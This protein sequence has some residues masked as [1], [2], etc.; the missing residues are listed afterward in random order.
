MTLHSRSLAT[1]LTTC[2]LNPCGPDASVAQALNTAL[3]SALS[4]HR[5]Q[6]HLQFTRKTRRPTISPWVATE[7][8]SM[9]VTLW[10][11]QPLFSV[12]NR[13]PVTS[14]S[15]LGTQNSTWLSAI[16]NL[17]LISTIAVLILSFTKTSES[18]FHKAGQLPILNVHS[19]CLD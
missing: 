18:L 13:Y 1:M 6:F 5:W 2:W 19:I 3:Q 8:S 11:F 12:E 9:T 10:I 16:A 4:Y 15:E 14:V 17:W 7:V